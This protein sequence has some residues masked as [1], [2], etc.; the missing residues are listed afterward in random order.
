MLEVYA[1]DL[2]RATQVVTVGMIFFSAN[3][4]KI[5]RFNVSAQTS[6]YSI[7]SWMKI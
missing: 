4:F 1:L 6:E 3:R 2:F 5:S 7:T